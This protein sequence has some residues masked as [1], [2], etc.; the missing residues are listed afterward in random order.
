[1]SNFKVGEVVIGIGFV[2][3]VHR[4]GVECVI[5]KGLNFGRGVDPKTREIVVDTRYRVQWPDG[6]FTRVL[7]HNLRRRAPPTTGEQSI[8]AL[9]LVTPKQK[10]RKVAIEATGEHP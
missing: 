3:D 5:A 7:Q 2:V 8:M 10:A 4:N 9:F 6:Q 1:M